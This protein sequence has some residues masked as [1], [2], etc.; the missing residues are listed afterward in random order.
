MADFQTRI[1]DI[2]GATASVGSD[3]AS[4]NEQAIQDAL[5]DTASDIINKVNPDILVQFATKSSNVTSNPIASNIE[6]SRIVLVERRE[7]DDTTDL[8]VSCVY[9]DAS[10]QGKIQNPHSIFFATDE[11][12]RWTFNDNDVYVYPEPAS[13]NPSRYYSMENPTILHSADTVAKFPNELEHA[14][15]LGAS[16]RLKQRQITFFNEDEDSEVVAM[17]RAQYQELLS[18]YANA[19]APFMVSSR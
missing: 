8:Y 14:L 3:N 17:H 13:A 4:A 9:L 16:A 7:S 12:P 2:I 19:L 5:Q 11:S 6:N 15:V 18:E 10:L 1:E